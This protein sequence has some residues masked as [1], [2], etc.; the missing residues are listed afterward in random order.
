M[1]GFVQAFQGKHGDGSP[2]KQVLKLFLGHGLL[3]LADDVP[4]V[5]HL[6][7]SLYNGAARPLHVGLNLFGLRVIVLVILLQDKGLHVSAATAS[8]HRR[9]CLYSQIGVG[10]FCSRGCKQLSFHL[11][12]VRS[13][14][15]TSCQGSGA[16][17]EDSRDFFSGLRDRRTQTHTLTS[18]Q[19]QK[20]SGKPREAPGRSRHAMVSPGASLKG[21]TKALTLSKVLC[22]LDKALNPKRCKTFS[23][24]AITCPS[25]CLRKAWGWKGQARRVSFT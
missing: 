18:R 5:F 8:L 6:S 25:Y 1:L 11:R 4:R 10:T 20:G 23:F 14:L 21:E 2:R 24:R 7:H 22:T 12:R 19:S 13:V 3:L 16:T 9:W 17:V 15:R